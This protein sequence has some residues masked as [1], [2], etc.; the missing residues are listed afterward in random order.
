MTDFDKR[1]T[2]A[3]GDIAAAH[4]DG[5]VQA[6]RFV[7]GKAFQVSASVASIRK[8]PQSTAGLETQ[9]MRG[10]Q[11]TL[12]DI[13]TDSGWGW[14]QCDADD[15]VGYVAL[16]ELSDQLMEPTHRV[17]VLRTLVFSEPDL[18]SP[19]AEMLSLNSLVQVTKVIGHYG[20]LARG[21]YVHLPHLAEPTAFADDFVSVAEMFRGAP[22]WWGGKDSLGLD[23]SGLVQSAMRA[24][25]FNPPR[26]S[27]MQEYSELCGALIEISPDLS[28]LQRGDLVFWPGH[29]GVML[30]S[31]AMLHANAHH[32]MC[33]REPL[34]EAAARIEAATGHPI[35]TIRRP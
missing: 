7:E 11:I 1:L 31:E 28:G 13:D 22:Y 18:K 25:G 16:S 32:M 33:E 27:D 29:V 3:R 17:N 8:A 10:E 20:E 23:C 5:Q 4:L 6:D 24:A 30:N 15:F 9:A 2:P 34:R 26:D 21:G 12:Y 19:P 35:R 14:G